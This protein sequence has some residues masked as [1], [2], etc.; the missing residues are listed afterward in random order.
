MAEAKRRLAAILAADV[1]GYSRLMGDDERATMDTLMSY[2]RVFRKHIS[3][4]EGRVVDTAGDSVLAVFDSVVEAVEYAAEVQA[5]LEGRNAQLP[6]HRRM[7]FR[8]GVN[9]G[10]VIIQDDG[11]IYGDGVNVAARLEGLAEP[12]GITVSED[13]PKARG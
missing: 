11:S 3:D 4:H 9:L 7:L 2:R 6:E 1:V 8:I 10:D 13:V 12:G 5:D